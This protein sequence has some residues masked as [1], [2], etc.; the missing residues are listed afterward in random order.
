G[1]VLGVF[2]GARRE[3]T[4]RRRL[5]VEA[6]VVAAL[7]ALY[8]VAVAL[9][10]ASRVREFADETDNLLGGLLIARGERLYVDYFSSHMPFAYY[11]SAIP[12]LFG[13]TT[14]EHF[15]LFSNTLLVATTL[16]MVYAF[17]RDL[18]LVTLGAWATLT[19]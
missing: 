18:P 15:R 16:C 19:V 13:A 11:L 5:T 8:A 4:E 2:L 6:N 7:A 9:L 12:A 17:R 1:R 10:V 14:L 3:A